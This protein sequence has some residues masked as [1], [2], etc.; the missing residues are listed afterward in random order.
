[1]LPPLIVNVIGPR[2]RLI[3]IAQLQ[4]AADQ[5]SEMGRSSTHDQSMSPRH[6]RGILRNLATNH[7][8]LASW[9]ALAVRVLRI[10]GAPRLKVFFVPVLVSVAICKETGKKKAKAPGCCHGSSNTT[11]GLCDWRLRRLRFGEFS[12]GKAEDGG[13]CLSLIHHCI[14]YCLSKKKLLIILNLLHTYQ[15]LC[16]YIQWC[17]STQQKLMNLGK[18]TYILKRRE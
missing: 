14:D 12:H 7:A 2:R 15:N 5:P 4:F 3:P 18:T 17:T 1:M 13:D 10:A 8:I 11:C 9:L 6:R 16:I